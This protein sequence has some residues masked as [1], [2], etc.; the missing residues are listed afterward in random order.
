MVY[1]FLI[2]DPTCSRFRIDSYYRGYY[3]TYL[4]EKLSWFE[5][6][7]KCNKEGGRLAVIDNDNPDD[8][9]AIVNA[10]NS[11]MEACGRNWEN[12]VGTLWIGLK[13]SNY[14]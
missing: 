4:N 7:G 8:K 14:R 12:D 2:E 13:R 1:F 10:I 5:A 9:Q 6:W 3:K 11:V